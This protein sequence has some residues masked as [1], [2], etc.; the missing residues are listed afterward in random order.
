M[1]IDSAQKLEDTLLERKLITSAQYAEIK[2]R[3]ISSDISVENIILE[4]N[5]ISENQLAEL[6]SEKY[7]IKFIDPSQISIPGEV[8][9]LI[10]ESVAKKYNILAV[11]KKTDSI[12][13]AMIDPLDLQVVQFIERSVGLK[14]VP[15]IATKSSMLDSIER[16]YSK[17]L[18]KDVNIAIE[19]A[20]ETT[21]MNQ[22]ETTI[23]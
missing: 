8:V 15:Y 12:G 9:Q 5:Y 18:G 21:A 10:S 3:I 1:P 23:R 4:G 16:E 17:S 11:E 19:E 6:K 7:G 14:V 2:R 13:L 22:S 20:T